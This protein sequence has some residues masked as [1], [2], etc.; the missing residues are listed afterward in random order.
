MTNRDF[1]ITFSGDGD[2]EWREYVDIAEQSGFQALGVGDSQSIYPDVYVR[3]TVAALRTSRMRIGAWV[4]NPVTRHPAVTYSAIR[5]VDSISG[6]RAFLGIGTGFSSLATLGVSPA[7]LDDLEEY[8]SV[9]RGLQTHGEARWRG[10]TI[11]A[12]PYGRR[13]PVYVAATGPKAL[14]LAGRIGDGVIMLNGVT[15]EVVEDSLAQLR[16]GAESAG[17]SVEEIEAWWAVAA[18]LAEDDATALAEMSGTLATFANVAFSSGQKAPPEYAEAMQALRAQYE[19]M[20]H[21]SHGPSRQ[22]ALVRDLGLLPYFAQRF[23][24]CGGPDTFVQMAL[25]ARRAG[26]RR[27]WLTMRTAQKLRFLRLWGEAVRSRLI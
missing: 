19:M 27:L 5:S 26:A 15:P 9:V 12:E 21:G 18:N 11:K 4:T 2:D 1:A 20:K 6:G 14:Q 16:R 23:A 3:L 25:A 22:E 24:L 10:A 7:R 13:I 17:R 8:V